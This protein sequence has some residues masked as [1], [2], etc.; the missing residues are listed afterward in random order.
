M[1]KAKLVDNIIEHTDDALIIIGTN[2][3]ILTAN[4][5][6]LDLIDVSEEELIGS[7]YSL[8]FTQQTQNPG[9]TRIINDGLRKGVE[10]HLQEMRFSAANQSEKNVLISTSR[11]SEQDAFGRVGMKNSLL[12]FIKNVGTVAND[13]QSASV[14]SSQEYQNLSKEYNRLQ[15]KNSEFQTIFKRFDYVKLAI[16]AVIFLIFTYAIFNLQ[17]TIKS[18]TSPTPTDTVKQGEDRIVTATLDTMDKYIVVSGILE[19]HNKVTIAAQTSGKVVARNFNEGDYVQMDQILYQMDTKELA[20]N[21]RSARIRYIELLEEYNNLKKW[22]SSLT[23]MQAQRKFSLSKIAVNNE[24]KKLAETKKLFDKGI[25]PRVEYEQAVTAYKKA[26][27]DFEN[28]K[29]SLESELDKGNTEKLEV[30]RLKLSNAKDELDEIEARYEATLIRAPVSGIVMLPVSSDGIRGTYKNEGDMVNDG[31]LVATIGATDSYIINSHIG[32]QAVQLLKV[33][34]EAQISGPGFKD[35]SITGNVNWIASS[36]TVHENIRYFPIRINI[37]S[38]PDSLKQYLRLGMFAEASIL[39]DRYEGVVTIPI[40]AVYYDGNKEKITVIH[41]D[42]TLEERTITAGPS[43][44]NKVAVMSGLAPGEQ[45]I[46]RNSK[47]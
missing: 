7:S 43:E 14:I 13:E 38:V 21:V 27:Y 11:I 34:Q 41:F 17:S 36:A 16:I 20:K 9:I 19:P 4:T 32:E 15:K 29:Q 12:L 2:G 45:I 39:Y 28:A 46:V 10:Y 33:G 40:E 31:D 44:G 6:A 8:F 26:E 24:K 30:L 25:I 37:L 5:A 18:S 23:V 35:F 1:K 47:K 22:D 42:E 3:T